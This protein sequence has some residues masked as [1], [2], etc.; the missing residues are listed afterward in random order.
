MKSGTPPLPQQRR[1]SLESVEHSPVSREQQL[2]FEI[3]VLDA[4]NAFLE[5]AYSLEDALVG[6]G[7]L[8]SFI[9]H[10]VNGGV[11]HGSEC[12]SRAAAAFVG[13]RYVR[14]RVTSRTVRADPFGQTAPAPSVRKNRTLIVNTT[15]PP[16]GTTSTVEMKRPPTP[17]IKAH[18][19]L[20]RR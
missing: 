1:M 3:A 17:A 4:F 18:K 20:H 15:A 10:A 16:L 13:G 12:R 5:E 11:G 2:R 8:N 6:A 9:R 14:S 19:T 7:F